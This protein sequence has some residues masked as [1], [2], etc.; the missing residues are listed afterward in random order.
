MSGTNLIAFPFRLN[1]A[2]GVATNPQ[3]GESYYGE[4]IGVLLTTQPG[5]RLMEP[6][7]GTPDMA[8]TGGFSMSALDL[9]ISQ[10]LPG[11]RA[12]AVSIKHISDTKQE[13]VISFNPVEV[14]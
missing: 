8:F 9:Q 10:Y 7:L 3:Y 6:Q 14:K 5:E 12:K 11:I 13:V 4:Q 1:P 2:G